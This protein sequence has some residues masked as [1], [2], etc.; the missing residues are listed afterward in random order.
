[1]KI[2]RLNQRFAT[3]CLIFIAIFLCVFTVLQ[4]VSFM[5]TGMEQTQLIESVFTEIGLECG[6]LILKR[7]RVKPGLFCHE[8]MSDTQTY[9]RC[10][11]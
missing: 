10:G 3:K 1:M 7:I 11:I 8:S 4:Y 6:C 5:I 9:M 2:P